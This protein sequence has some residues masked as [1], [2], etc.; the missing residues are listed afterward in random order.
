MA[1]ADELAARVVAAG[2]RCS[3]TKSVLAEWARR[4]TPRQVEYL[5]G[6][7]EAECASRCIQSSKSRQFALS[8]SHTSLGACPNP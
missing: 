6:Y 2:R 8:I 4:G 1:V 7:L 5:A 3:L